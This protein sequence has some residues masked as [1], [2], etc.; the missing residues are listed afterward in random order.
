MQLAAAA[1]NNNITAAATDREPLRPPRD[2]VADAPVH[3]VRSPMAEC[4]G[5]PSMFLLISIATAVLPLNDRAAPPCTQRQAES[6]VRCCL[7]SPAHRHSII[8][9]SYFLRATSWRAPSTAST[10]WLFAV[11]GICVMSPA[12]HASPNHPV[13]CKRQLYERTGL[14]SGASLSSG[15]EMERQPN[16]TGCRQRGWWLN[17]GP[18]ESPQTDSSTTSGQLVSVIVSSVALRRR[19]R[20]IARYLAATDAAA[21]ALLH[22]L[23]AAA[24]AA[25][26]MP[27]LRDVDD[28]HTGRITLTLNMRVLYHGV[29]IR[30]HDAARRNWQVNANIL[31]RLILL[32]ILHRTR[33]IPFARFFD[34]RC[35]SPQN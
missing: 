16:A 3:W 28:V 11:Y 6:T 25:A 10:D 22:R 4:H 30:Q 33:S 17:V 12:A 29:F 24:A 19:R 26:D 27:I 18:F 34:N 14:T 7:S 21:S 31:S 1:G 8:S 13:N 9:T 5:S 23:T 35:K 2:D 15:V 20:R 32:E